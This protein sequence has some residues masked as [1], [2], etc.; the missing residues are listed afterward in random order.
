MKAGMKIGD[1]NLATKTQPKQQIKHEFKF[2][3]GEKDVTKVLDPEDIKALTDVR[4]RVNIN[5]ELTKILKNKGV[6]EEQIPEIVKS[7]NYKNSG[8]ELHQYG[9]FG[10]DKLTVIEPEKEHN[11]DYYLARPKKRQEVLSN[12]KAAD[13]AS[14][15]NPRAAA[16]W[17]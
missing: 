5:A 15:G 3:D 8:L 14:A 16:R 10:K 17:F 11:F 9:K 1:A 7:F 6:P 4:G 2:K 13:V 12:A